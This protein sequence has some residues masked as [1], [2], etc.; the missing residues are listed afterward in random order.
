[1]SCIGAVAL[2]MGI[3]RKQCVFLF[4][5]SLCYLSQLVGSYGALLLKQVVALQLDASFRLGV[6]KSHSSARQLETSAAVFAEGT[7]QNRLSAS[8]SN[9]EMQDGSLGG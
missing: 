3:P 8:R 6:P 2:R 5:E 9:P 4:L 7:S 1:M